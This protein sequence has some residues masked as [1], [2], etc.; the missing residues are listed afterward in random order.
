MNA[1]QGFLSLLGRVLLASIFFVA[2]RHHFTDFDRINE[3]LT[4]K[5]IPAPKVIHPLAIGFMSLGAI[6]IV[7]GYKARI[8]AFLLFVF[9]GVAG[10]YFHDFWHLAASM[11]RE[12]ALTQ[13][14]KNLALMGAMLFIMANGPGAWSLDC[15]LAKTPP[16]GD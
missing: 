6:S 14:L 8:G 1:L 13:F 5:G 9:L 4:T 7:L 12:D 10:Y 3:L 2:L 15:C 16:P 11:D